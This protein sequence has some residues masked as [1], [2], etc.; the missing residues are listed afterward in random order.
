MCCYNT[1]SALQLIPMKFTLRPTG[2]DSN[3]TITVKNQNDQP[4]A[5]Q[6]FV[7]TRNVDLD[8]NENNEE[9]EDNF[10]IYPPQLIV[11]PNSQKTVRLSW[12]GDPLITDELAY[13]LVAEQLPID[14]GDGEEE[15]ENDAPRLALKLLFRY[16]AAFYVTP[17][18]CA[19]NVTIVSTEEITKEDGSQYIAITFENDG[20]THQYLLDM[21]ITINAMEKEGSLIKTITL[22]PEDI[23]RIGTWNILANSK[24]RFF[25]PI[26]EDFPTGHELNSTFRLGLPEETQ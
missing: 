2:R 7:T 4:E 24:R 19:P 1:V 16:E 11:H 14:L 8:G 20:N 15:E 10:L 26:P 23:Q 25:I 22:T 18:K 12:I 5:V 9:D 6:I 13:R 3:V 17:F 21:Y